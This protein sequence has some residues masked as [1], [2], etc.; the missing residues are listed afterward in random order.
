M[1]SLTDEQ[2]RELIAQLEDDGYFILPELLPE[3][4][5]KAALAAIDRVTTAQR[6]DH[7]RRS[8]K[9]ANC[10]VHDPALLDLAL[11]EPALQ[12]AYDVFGPMFHLCQSNFV[13]RPNDGTGKSD[14][15]SASPWHADGPRPGLFPKIDGAMGLHYLKFGYFLTDLTHGNGGSLQ[16]VRGSH[17]RPEL[18]GKRGTGFQ[19]EDYARDL[20]KLDCP[21]GTVVAFHQAQWHAAPPNE[22]PIE[23]KNA[24]ISYCPTWMRPLDRE[25]PREGEL[26]GLSAEARW[27]LGEWRPAQ[28][29]WLPQPEDVQR[30]A[31]FRRTADTP[32]GAVR[33]YD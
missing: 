15:V 8:V 26:E 14:F 11:Y 2:R 1:P 22:S 10:V 32:V 13:S 24:Y 33:N 25:F 7:T 4:L 19:I 20:V 30:M 5:C 16:V 28:R 27:L 21:A 23:R 18:D 9:V 12:L 6:G 3:A 17:K 31:R 29:W